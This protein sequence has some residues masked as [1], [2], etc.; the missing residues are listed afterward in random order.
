MSLN[1]FL[2][3]LMSTSKDKKP[4]STPKVVLMMSKITEN[5][6]SSLNYSDLSKTIHLYLRSILMANHL[7]KDPPIDNSKERWLED[8]IRLFLQICNSIEGK[9]F[10]LINH[11]E[12]VQKLT[13]YLEF[14]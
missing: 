11:C 7:D 9:V 10:T 5:K 6:L 12:F 3:F 13:E 14:V 4:V 2:G 1:S 8:D